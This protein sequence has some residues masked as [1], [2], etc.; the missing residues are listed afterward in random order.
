MYS[1]NINLYLS[2]EGPSLFN[3]SFDI[4]TIDITLPKTDVKINAT[5]NHSIREDNFEKLLI[6]ITNPNNTINRN[7][8]YKFT[9]SPE[10]VSGIKISA[11]LFQTT[12]VK[13]D[14]YKILKS[15]GTVEDL[16]YQTKRQV[17][18]PITITQVSPLE[19]NNNYE[20]RIQN[21]NSKLNATILKIEQDKTMALVDLTKKSDC[22]EQVKATPSVTSDLCNRDWWKP[23]SYIVT[24]PE[25]WVFENQTT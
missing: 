10:K 8:R 13:S 11:Q 22:S 3:N 18:F 25:E 6:N 5:I 14:K 15:D 12:M 23:S 19:P 7:L 4:S 20:I 17:H 1:S 21:H 16:V 9:S 2:W 24:S